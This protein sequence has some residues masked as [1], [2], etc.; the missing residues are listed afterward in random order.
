MSLLEKKNAWDEP[1]A[2][3]MHVWYQTNGTTYQ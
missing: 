2:V 3:H 1:L